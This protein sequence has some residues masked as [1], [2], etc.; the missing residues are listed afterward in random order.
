MLAA[1]LAILQGAVSTLRTHRDLLAEI[2]A[3]RQQ[4]A[5]YKRTVQG[6]KTLAADRLLWVTLRRLWPGWRDVLVIVKPETVI[7]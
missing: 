1:L 3:V 2:A 4:L 5:I 6:P 7:A